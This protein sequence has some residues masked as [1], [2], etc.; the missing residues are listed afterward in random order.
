M[1]LNY[2]QSVKNGAPGSGRVN[3]PAARNAPRRARPLNL[4]L[5][6]NHSTKFKL[7][8][9]LPPVRHSG[10]SDAI[11]TGQYKY[12][13]SG[14]VTCHPRNYRSQPEVD[15]GALPLGP[16]K[17]MVYFLHLAWSGAGS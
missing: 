3:A 13:D 2:S 11:L 10:R 14:C 9:F 5:Q 6:D 12:P 4:I 15:H 8:M 17:D 1:P 7:F 16:R